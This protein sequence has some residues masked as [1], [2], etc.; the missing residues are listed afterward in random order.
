[1]REKLKVL[2]GKI[3]QKATLGCLNLDEEKTAEP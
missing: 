1:M 2:K 3:G